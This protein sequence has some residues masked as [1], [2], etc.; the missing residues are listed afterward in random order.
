MKVRVTIA[1]Y[2][3]DR[4]LNA[5]REVDLKDGS[6]VKDLLKAIDSQHLFDLPVGKALLRAAESRI[7][8]VNGRS[9][10]L[11]DAL[12]DRLGEGDD[13]SFLSA[14]AGG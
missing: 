11:A 7:A 10:P 9:T 1:G 4:A 6:T 8:L 14:I 3:G 2:F 12:K 13:V 5:S